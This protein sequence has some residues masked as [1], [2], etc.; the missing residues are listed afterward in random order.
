MDAAAAATS[1]GLPTGW[2]AKQSKGGRWTY[3]A[4]DDETFSSLASAKT[5]AAARKPPRV[6]KSPTPHGAAGID[7]SSGALAR[8]ADP[9]RRAQAAAAAAQAE[10]VLPAS[11]DDGLS[12]YERER[13]GCIARNEAFMQS[14]GLGGG[15]A[16]GTTGGKRAA[17]SQRG[18]ARK[19]V[20]KAP[21]GPARRS[22][23]IE[24]E[25]TG[26]KAILVAPAPSAAGPGSYAERERLTGD[27]AY[28][29]DGFDDA[30]IGQP[31]AAHQAEV[32]AARVTALR[33]S[34]A[35]AEAVAEAEA[36]A[37][38]DNEENVQWL[39]DVDKEDAAEQADARR[40]VA[41]VSNASTGTRKALTDAAYKESLRQMRIRHVDIAKVTKARTY[42]LAWQ[43][44]ADRLLIASGDVNGQLGLWDVDE[45]DADRCCWSLS[46]AHSRPVTALYWDG[47]SIISGGYDSLVRKCALD[48]APLVSQVVADYYD[49]DVDD[50]THFC[51]QGD[52]VWGAHK[53]GSFS[54]F[55]AR[56]APTSKKLIVDAH[57]RKCAHVGVR[58]GH[59]HQLTTSSNDS[60]L[61]VWDVRKLTK[62]TPTEVWAFEHAKSVHG[63]CWS[64]D[65]RTLASCSYDDTV[66]FHD[67]DADRSVSVAHV[68]KTGRYLTPFKPCMDPHAPYASVVMGS[69]GRPR[70]VDVLRATAPHTL[71]KLNDR[72]DVF[73]SV[74][75]LHDVHPY[76]HVIAGANNSGRL[77]IWRQS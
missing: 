12:Q 62:K 56:Q 51:L 8:A 16:G 37:K 29:V 69:M 64:A 40:L 20:R 77:S 65:G 52:V 3:V 4:P 44:R 36:D 42:S 43:P 55:D 1:K 74:T 58:P 24:E 18:V 38:V 10:A 34:G 25:R 26:T 68:N 45:A 70:C 19:K 71:I 61:V 28:R 31:R 49:D 53:C 32:A 66:A 15:L 63:F 54:R 5:A 67:V 7:R 27:H 59:E 30:R 46:R 9:V 60:S 21:A 17:A 6:S 13:L 23:R 22:P 35:E 41:R 14:L 47:G 75:S 48:H 73:H 57:G 76:A 72:D 11:G 2:T 39:A 33:A 50:L